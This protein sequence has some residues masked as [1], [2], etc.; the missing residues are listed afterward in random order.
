MPEPEV[1]SRAAASTARLFVA[2]WP[3]MHTRLALAAWRDACTWPPGAK[4]VPDAKLHLTLHFIGA[5]PQTRVG[6]L[7]SRLAV[8]ARPVVLTLT[9]IAVWP[10]GLVVLEPETVPE[11]ACTLHAELAAALRF[12]GLPVERRRLRPHV[13]LARDAVGAHGPGR[14][15]AL[16]WRTT[17]HALVKSLP[18]GRYH[19]LRHY[20]A[21]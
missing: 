10:R 1:A 21:A 8:P 3:D 7:M 6:E 12:L 11:A 15:P 9:Q 19:V 4:P 16:V 2:L 20:R 13:T 14:H 17:G 5:V 18:D